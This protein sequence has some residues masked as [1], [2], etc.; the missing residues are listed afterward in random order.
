MSPLHSLRPFDCHA[1][2]EAK[3]KGSIQSRATGRMTA[4]PQLLE[5]PIAAYRIPRLLQK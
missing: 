1:M 2:L 4:L 3:I 5:Q